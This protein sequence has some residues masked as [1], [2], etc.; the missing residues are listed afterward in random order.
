MTTTWLCQCNSATC[1]LRVQL[2][3]DVAEKFQQNNEVVIV[4]GCKNGP[5][6]D[7]ILVEKRERYSVYKSVE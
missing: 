3:L 1:T 4:V 2:E 6:K 5:S 7:D